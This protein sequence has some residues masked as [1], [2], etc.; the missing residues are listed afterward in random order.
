MTGLV[1]E[2]P[3]NKDPQV[4][5]SATDAFSLTGP[6]GPHAFPWAGPRV[7]LRISGSLPSAHRLLCEREE[8]FTEPDVDFHGDRWALCATQLCCHK[9]ARRGGDLGESDRFL[10]PCSQL[11][12]FQPAPL[13]AQNVSLGPGCSTG[14]Q[15]RSQ[16]SC[17]ALFQ[18]VVGT[19]KGFPEP[20]VLGRTP[21]TAEPARQ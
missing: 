18:R 15:V 1:R 9:P 13:T 8:E 7:N 3:E 2:T 4:N 17:I 6:L 10:Q 5:L 16:H 12:K 11:T 19:L 20:R 14:S 21:L